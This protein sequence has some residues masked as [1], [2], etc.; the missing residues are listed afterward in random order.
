[1][2]TRF[3]AALMVTLSLS[4]SLGAT[5]RS[6]PP[7]EKDLIGVWIGFEEGQLTFTRLDLRANSIGYCAR[8]SAGSDAEVYRIR[9]WSI[10]GWDLQIDVIPLS[11]N[12]ESI[13]L[14][15]LGGRAYLQLRIGAV[16]GRWQR[17]LVLSPEL[18]IEAANQHA[19]QAIG[20]AEK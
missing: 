4:A 8:I 2:R 17:K 14:K 18:D 9:N 15:G 16:G 12:V 6:I 20:Y 5:K 19:K 7:T 10:R 1:M 11:P 3:I 13:Y